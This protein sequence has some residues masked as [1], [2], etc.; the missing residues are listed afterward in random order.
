MFCWY[1]L[2]LDTPL[3]GCR[4][5][6]FVSCRYGEDVSDVGGAGVGPGLDPPIF[7]RKDEIAFRAVDQVSHDGT[8][9]R[10][11]NRGFGRGREIELIKVA[12]E[13]IIKP[14]GSVELEGRAGDKLQLA[15]SS[16][17]FHAGGSGKAG[18]V[19][20]SGQYVLVGSSAQSPERSATI[21][22]AGKRKPSENRNLPIAGHRP[23]MD[24]SGT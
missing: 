20:R 6:E 14:K 24:L 10:A 5:S 15:P 12:G 18:D 13:G 19:V 7:R 22:F 23:G 21:G 2:S 16:R 4:R 11:G 8:V 17:G 9:S 3:V 1:P